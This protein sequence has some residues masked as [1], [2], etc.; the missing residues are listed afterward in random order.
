[1]T[2]VTGAERDAEAAALRAT[3]MKLQDIA[4]RLGYAGPSKV[5]EGIAR[6]FKRVSTPGVEVL[7]AQQQQLID[8][9]KLEA[10]GVLRRD[11]VAHSQGRIVKAGCPGLDYAGERQHD[12]CTYQVAGQPYCD[13][14]PVLDDGPKLQAISTIKALLDREAKLHGLD[15]P[16]RVEE[17]TTGVASILEGVS[18]DDL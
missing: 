17:T 16:I 13:G 5:N 1:M 9:L 14:P 11:H 4:D 12:G 8:A 18:L 10:V 2:T 15:A 3:G 7:R 6:A